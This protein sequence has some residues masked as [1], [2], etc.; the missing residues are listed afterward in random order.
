MQVHL[1]KTLFFYLPWIAEIF[2]FSEIS[3]DIEVVLLK[4]FS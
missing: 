3:V 1:G 4:I 2:W